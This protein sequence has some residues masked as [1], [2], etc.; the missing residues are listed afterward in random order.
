MYFLAVDN[1]DQYGQNTAELLTSPAPSA[2]VTEEAEGAKPPADADCQAGGSDDLRNCRDVPRRAKLD[3]TAQ[4][5]ARRRE[6]VT[7]KGTTVKSVRG[8][9]SRFSTINFFVLSLRCESYHA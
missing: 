4:C 8:F 7:L 1:L 5:Q 3:A 2:S 9:A 6:S